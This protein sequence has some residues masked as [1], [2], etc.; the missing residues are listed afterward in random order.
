[1]KPKPFKLP[2]RVRIDSKAS[3]KVIRT[4]S[5]EGDPT[6]IGECCSATKTISLLSSLKGKSLEETFYH[7]VMH[8]II[9]ECQFSELVGEKWEETLVSAIE[10][11]MA[12][13]MRLNNL[14]FK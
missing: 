7:E 9:A 6:Q 3:Y 4:D 13:F 14:R 1:M 8:A 10:R 11:P 5:F 12:K 2:N